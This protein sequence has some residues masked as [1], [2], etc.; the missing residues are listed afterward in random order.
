MRGKREEVGVLY[1]QAPAAFINTIALPHLFSAHV[2][3]WGR[4]VGRKVEGRCVFPLHL[5]HRP[6]LPAAPFPALPSPLQLATCPFNRPFDP[7]NNLNCLP[8]PKP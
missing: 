8:P 3:V 4:G 7:F 5:S 1:A 6:G 2:R